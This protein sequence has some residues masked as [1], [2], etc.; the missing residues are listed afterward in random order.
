MVIASP[1][2]SLPVPRISRCIHSVPVIYSCFTFGVHVAKI[3]V[4]F[5][6][7][8][9]TVDIKGKDYQHFQFLFELTTIHRKRMNI[10]LHSHVFSFK[11]ISGS[12]SGIGRDIK[13]IWIEFEF[14]IFLLRRSQDVKQRT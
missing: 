2:L 11:P 7:N 12:E 10:S 14:N 13:L 5:V 9:C 8:N 6:D 1:S 4:Q 3:V